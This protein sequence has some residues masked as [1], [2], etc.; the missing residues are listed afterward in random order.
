MDGGSRETLGM[1][2]FEVRET[3]RRGDLLSR[4]LFSVLR[5]GEEREDEVERREDEVE[6]KEGEKDEVERR[7]EEVEDKLEGCRAGQEEG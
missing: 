4:S 7:E 6:R 3:E 2:V 5:R 1:A